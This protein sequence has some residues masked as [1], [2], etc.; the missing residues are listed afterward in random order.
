MMRRF[1]CRIGRARGVRFVGDKPGT[2]VGF[3][4]NVDEVINNIHLSDEEMKR[5]VKV[6]NRASLPELLGEDPQNIIPEAFYESETVDLALAFITAVDSLNLSAEETRT[7]EDLFDTAFEGKE[8]SELFVKA[9][10]CLEVQTLRENSECLLLIG[11]FIR[12]S[13]HPTHRRAVLSLTYQCY[14]LPHFEELWTL[15]KLPAGVAVSQDMLFDLVRTGTSQH[16]DVLVENIASDVEL[17]SMV[18]KVSADTKLAV[19]LKEAF[20]AFQQGDDLVDAED[21]IKTLAT[22]PDSKQWIERV[23]KF[24]D[25]NN[26][27]NLRSFISS[28][29]YGE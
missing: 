2:D 11:K 27:L 6:S 21:V 26:K 1:A 15:H 3:G 9:C 22:L 20:A 17:S 29:V 7:V 14:P 28:L 24:K 18:T 23:D 12:D 13:I 8:P 4:Q 16:Y 25:E 10:L 5:L 19:L